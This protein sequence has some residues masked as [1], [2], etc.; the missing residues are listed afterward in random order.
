VT[1]FAGDIIGSLIGGSLSHPAEKYPS[2]F[3]RFDWL[4]RHPFFLP[5][6]TSSVI[7]VVSIV[8]AVLLLRET[9]PVKVALACE[10]VDEAGITVSS[11]ESIARPSAM[12]LLSDARVRGVVAV[13]FFLSFLAIAWES[14]FILF[15]Y[16]PAYLGGLERTAAEIGVL[17]ATLGVFSMTLATIAFPAL[18]HRFGTTRVLRMC[19]SL[20]PAVFVLFS[21]SSALA[22]LSRPRSTGSQTIAT[23]IG[24][25]TGVFSLLVVGRVACLAYPAIYIAMKDAAPSRE[26]LGA[27]FSLTAIAGDVARAIGPGFVSSLFALSIDRQIFQGQLV[28]LIMFGVAVVGYRFTS[29]L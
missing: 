15:A 9:L 22:R 16:T 17:L 13:E 6:F 3:G 10:L 28:W 27:M 5:C 2:I 24:M 4:R 20:W 25:W 19:M 21:A 26:S 1:W 14:V 29:L 12:F 7:T 18:H 23:K 11:T 8:F